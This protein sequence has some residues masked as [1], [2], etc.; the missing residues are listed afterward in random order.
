[1]FKT[2]EFHSQPDMS[3]GGDRANHD[4]VEKPTDRIRTEHPEVAE[5]LDKAYGYVKTEAAK[6]DKK[7]F[8]DPQQTSLALYEA[9]YGALKGGNGA[10]K[11]PEYGRYSTEKIF[12][13]DRGLERI[14]DQAGY[15]LAYELLA[16]YIRANFKK[17]EDEEIR[18]ILVD[19]LEKMSRRSLW[20]EERFSFS[21]YEDK[22]FGEMMKKYREAGIDV[23]DELTKIIVEKM[24][25]TERIKKSVDRLAE[26][27][28]NNLNI[29]HDY[30]RKPT[31]A[32]ELLQKLGI[33]EMSQNGLDHVAGS[34]TGKGFRDGLL[35]VIAGLQRELDDREMEQFMAERR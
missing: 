3:S 7:V 18:D 28:N 25:S 16:N 24:V 31:V 4:N 11:S 32:R 13:E 14:E 5:N 1:M 22:E 35:S 9:V 8:E 2:Q 15:A 30:A 17:A 23:S 34:A 10:F 33:R 27:I 21:D 29:I 12:G 26:F 20:Q 6:M 19:Y